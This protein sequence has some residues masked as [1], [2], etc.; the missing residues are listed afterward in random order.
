MPQVHLKSTLIHDIPYERP[1]QIAA[2]GR[3]DKERGPNEFASPA[4]DWSVEILLT[5]PHWSDTPMAINCPNRRSRQASN[6][7]PNCGSLWSSQAAVE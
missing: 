2:C 1:K 4:I 3:L 5:N 7:R 6:V